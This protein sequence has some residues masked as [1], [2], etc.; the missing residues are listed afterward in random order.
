[1]ICVYLCC[2]CSALKVSREAAR[3]AERSAGVPERDPH[4]ELQRIAL[5]CMLVIVN[6]FTVLIETESTGKMQQALQLKRRLYETYHQVLSDKDQERLAQGV[7]PLVQEMPVM[8]YAQ[9][10]GTLDRVNTEMEQYLELASKRAALEA[11][12]ELRRRLEEE[13]SL[14][15]SSIGDDSSVT[16]DPKQLRKEKREKYAEQR[17]I[18]GAKRVEVTKQRKVL[19]D[20]I[21][22]DR[23][24]DI[25]NARARGSASVKAEWSEDNEQHMAQLNSEMDALTA[26]LVST[27][28][29]NEL[30]DEATRAAKQSNP[31]SPS[32]QSGAPTPSKP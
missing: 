1:M 2:I 29:E 8:P 16:K 9:V 6:Y 21:S 31:P 23:I 32:K 22:T 7:V 5:P 25:F 11:E 19:Y 15:D 14:L 26:T 13:A 18:D 3:A 4:A 20:L 28:V 27:A 30:K 12:A 17:R 24:T 10:R